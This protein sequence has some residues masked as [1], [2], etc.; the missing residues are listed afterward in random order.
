MA[1]PNMKALAAALFT[2]TITLDAA[3]AA[4]PSLPP[5]EGG[6]TIRREQ[7]IS[8]GEGRQLLQRQGFRQVRTINCRGTYFAYGAQRSNLQYEITVDAR[9]GQIVDLRRVGN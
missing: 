3:C 9:N 8:C 1:H 6:H 7:S 4:S 5:A 2:A